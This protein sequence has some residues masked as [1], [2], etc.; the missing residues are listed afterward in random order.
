MHQ[1]SY[2]KINVK[3]PL[4]YRE[5]RLSGTLHHEVGTHFFRW[6][7]HA[8]QKCFKLREKAAKQSVLS[9]EEGL[10]S[11]NQL[12]DNALDARFKPYLYKAAMN[13]HFSILAS[14]MSFA[15]LY[16]AMEP[17]YDDPD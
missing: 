8:K 13:Y 5:H 16:R 6:S 14:E 17:V 3:L 15:E 1:K 7:N 12:L 9:A 2:S 4:Q 11:L 10:A